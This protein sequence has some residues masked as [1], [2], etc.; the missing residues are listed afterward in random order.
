MANQT[1]LQRAARIKN[2]RPL[3]SSPWKIPR[4]LRV[5][6][7]S[8]ENDR[9]THLKFLKHPTDHL[10]LSEPQ[11]SKSDGPTASCSR[12]FQ[13]PAPLHLYDLLCRLSCR[14][15]QTIS[16]TSVTVK[17]LHVGTH[18]YERNLLCSNAFSLLNSCTKY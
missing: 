7:M 14:W 15:N 9:T 16:C 8:K 10:T 13:K 11:I 5:P 1:T 2:H 17:K 18:V 6:H 12:P 3:P 4:G